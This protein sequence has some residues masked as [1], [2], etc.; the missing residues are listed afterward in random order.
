[1]EFVIGETYKNTDN[2]HLATCVGH[3]L[4]GSPILENEGGIFSIVLGT[5]TKWHW[6]GLPSGWRVIN[7]HYADNRGEYRHVGYLIPWND[8]SLAAGHLHWGIT[9]VDKHLKAFRAGGAK[10]KT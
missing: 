10:K 8:Q 2:G 7:T 3:K 1:M 5:E 4:N 6:I 9:D